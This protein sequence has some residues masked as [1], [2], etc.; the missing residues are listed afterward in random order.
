[1]FS[2]YFLLRLQVFFLPSEDAQDAD[3]LISQFPHL[4]SRVPDGVFSLVWLGISGIWPVYDHIVGPSVAY[5]NEDFLF[6]LPVNQLLCDSLHRQTVPVI[7]GS[8][9]LKDPLIFRSGVVIFPVSLQDRVIPES[10]E[11]GYPV[12]NPHAA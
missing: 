10:T 11:T 5:D 12:G 1:I 2:E 4:K 9:K 7:G 8:G 3:P 6:L